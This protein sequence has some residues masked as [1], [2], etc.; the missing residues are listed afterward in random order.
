MLESE[1]CG[2]NQIRSKQRQYKVNCQDSNDHHTTSSFLLF[3][4][5][6]QTKPPNR[7]SSPA[8]LRMPFMSLQPR[9]ANNHGFWAVMNA[10]PNCLC[11]IAF[12]A[13]FANCFG[14]V[15]TVSARLIFFK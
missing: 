4:A 2:T 6:S 11:W 14:A 13:V 10:Y 8:I 5:S 7:P 1:G 12:M 3:A 9:E 15:K